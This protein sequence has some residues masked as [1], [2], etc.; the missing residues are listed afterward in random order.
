MNVQICL[1]TALHQIQRLRECRQISG[2]SVT[3][4]F[5]DLESRV[6]WAAMCWDT[7]SALTSETRTLLSSG[8]RGAC[9]EPT[10]QVVRAFLA[11]SSAS[12]WQSEEVF[13]TDDAA[14]EIIT[15][16]GIANI[17][18]WKTITNLKEALREGVSEE[19]EIHAWEGV[20]DAIEMFSSSVRPLLERCE[21]KIQFL[22]Q[23]VRLGWYSLHLRYHLGIL[24]LANALRVAKRED[25]TTKFDKAERDTEH[26]AMVVLK[27]GLE[28]KYVVSELVEWKD[29]AGLRFG[30][31]LVAIDPYP[32]YAVDLVLLMYEGLDRRLLEKSIA[33]EKYFFLLSTLYEALRELP[34]T[35]KA[36]QNAQEAIKKENVG[37]NL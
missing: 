7:S 14:C 10:W 17:F 6:H 12:R 19:V 30:P 9:A 37:L 31:S 1:Q 16:A 29:N 5:L 25:F 8:L 21:R 24:L 27:F 23:K 2:A 34:Q 35:S 26:E 36:V 33:E 32:Q 11:A 15:V 28:N 18:I 22:S 3:E 13:V 4:Q 20:T